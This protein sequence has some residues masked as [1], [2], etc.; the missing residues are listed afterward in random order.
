MAEPDAK[1][2]VKDS[3][4]L[5][6]EVALSVESAEEGV[7]K[8]WTD[9]EE[10]DIVRK[11]DK[12][13]VP[14]AALMY[15]FSFLNRVN[16]SNARVLDFDAKAGVGQM[17]RDTGM[18][19]NMFNTAVSL[20]FITYV[21]GEPV[22]NLVMTA[23][24]PSVWLSRIMI[25]WGVFS[26]AF[27]GT[28]NFAG[29]VALRL[30]LGAAEAGLFPGVSYYLSFFYKRTELA[31]RVA[32][33]FGGA[34]MASAFSGVLAYGISQ[35]SGAG[36]LHAWKWIFLI[37]GLPT[38][39]VGILVYFFLPDA[40]A[41]AKGLTDRERE[42]AANRLKLD[43]ATAGERAFDK[44]KILPTLTNPLVWI[45]AVLFF[46]Y[47]SPG[48]SLTFFAPTILQALGFAGVQANLFIV[49]PQ[50]TG[51]LFL[52]G[53][54]YLSDKYK[55]RTLFMAACILLNVAG[56]L[57]L[58]LSRNG[59][60]SYAMMFLTSIGTN[61]AIPISIAL[62]SNNLPSHTERSLGLGIMLGLGNL[63]GIAAGQIYRTEDRPWYPIGHYTLV[64]I[65]VF[66][67]FLTLAARFYI[68]NLNKKHARS[69]AEREAKGE[70][71]SEQERNFK[72]AT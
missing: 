1:D 20:F 50:I 55:E 68:V 37:E 29:V 6:D 7:V 2:V 32:M 5:K 64:G 47:T 11:L 4:P 67:I 52:L 19:G 62:L 17:E 25:T 39:V 10:R 35:M 71:I 60:A 69:I 40:P 27:A 46:C 14:W 57:G 16:I 54:S 26:A 22:S 51:P 61:G 36:G 8:N 43:H 24:R 53:I 28:N 21:I 63:G 44:T 66:C 38:I 42:I 30:L 15:L 58:G 18:S 3:Q 33:F 31:F 70:V 12:M 34:G 72:Y 59:A 41:T 56:F 45:C 65:S 49:P 48:Y 9:E 23:V 13:I